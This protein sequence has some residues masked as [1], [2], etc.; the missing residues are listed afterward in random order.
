MIPRKP[1][2]TPN[3][4]D[5]ELTHMEHYRDRARSS[6]GDTDSQGRFRGQPTKLKPHQPLVAFGDTL[7]LSLIHTRQPFGQQGI[8]PPAPPAN[9]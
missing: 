4:A 7:V 3:L 8:L 6:G 5:K 1:K 2:A 9:R